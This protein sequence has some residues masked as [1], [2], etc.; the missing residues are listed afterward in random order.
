MKKDEAD[1]AGKSVSEMD[2][3]ESRQNFLGRVFL[4]HRVFIREFFACLEQGLGGQN[5]Q[6]TL[7][8]LKLSRFREHKTSWARARFVL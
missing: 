3:R 6:V 4:L 1:K 5:V 7:L 2:L 8:R